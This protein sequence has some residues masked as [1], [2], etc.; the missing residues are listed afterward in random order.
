MLANKGRY[1]GTGLVSEE[2][3]RQLSLGHCQRPGH[4]GLRGRRLTVKRDNG[5]AVL[6]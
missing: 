4:C 3:D 6:A 5:L 1:K 2:A